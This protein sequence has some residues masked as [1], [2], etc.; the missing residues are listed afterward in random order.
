MSSKNIIYYCHRK[1][2]ECFEDYI[3]SLGIVNRKV[4]YTND[5]E[6]DPTTFA[7]QG[8][9]HI[10]RYHL[11]EFLL[12]AA[13]NILVLNTEQMSEPTRHNHI[14]TLMRFGIK[15]IDY[16]LANIRILSRELTY[17]TREQLFYLPYQY[18]EAEVYKLKQFSNNPHFDVG[19]VHCATP[20]RRA[21][22]QQLQA[23]GLK[24]IDIRGWK[25]ERDRKI[26]KCK[27]LL[28]V[29]YE[30]NFSIFEHI[31]CDRW[32]FAGKRL[33][34]EQSE[35]MEMLDIRSGVHFYRPSDV[36]AAVRRYLKAEPQTLA[37]EIIQNRARCLQN[38]IKYTNQIKN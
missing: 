14:T 20:Y 38:F 1:G 27:I 13:K 19:I 7:D 4:Y 2:Y 32:V 28:N 17:S 36:I 22:L 3:D 8:N 9:V 5:A 16:S 31:R 37:P 30:Q 34:S 21:V 35:D 10:F 11:P 26:G 12:K 29:H 15:I 24:A 6:L 33:V 25:E 23:A 18:Q